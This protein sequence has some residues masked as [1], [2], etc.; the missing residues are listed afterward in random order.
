MA[1]MVPGTQLRQL[2]LGFSV[3]K[4]AQNLP[5]TA[6][7]TLYTV[8]G[9]SVIITCLFGLVSGTAIQ[10]QACTL[11]LGLV[12]TTGT[13]A[14]SGVA[15][16]TAITNKEIGTWVAPQSSSGVAG[17]LVVGTNAGAALFLAPALVVPA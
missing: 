17:A 8:S 4:A 11:A 1:S 7:A 14:S 13:A 5:Q 3:V 2:E 10:N 6:T 12:P 9:G 16:A 15:T